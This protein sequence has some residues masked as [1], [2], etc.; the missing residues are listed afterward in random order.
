MAAFK[1]WENRTGAAVLTRHCIQFRGER[2]RKSRSK[3]E[4]LSL[5]Q[6]VSLVTSF[7]AVLMLIILKFRASALWAQMYIHYL[8]TALQHHPDRQWPH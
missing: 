5:Q 8:E 1:K 6:A 7:A 2:M 3:Q 4:K